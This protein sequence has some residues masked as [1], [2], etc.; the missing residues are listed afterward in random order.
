MKRMASMALATLSS[1]SSIACSGD[2]SSPSGTTRHV[3]TVFLIVMENKAW[4]ELKGSDKAPYLNDT[5]LPMASHAEGYK[6]PKNG[7]LH[8]SEP[9]YIWLEAG[10]NLG[11]TNDDDP[12]KNHLAT[13]DHLVTYMEQAGVSWKSY[14]EDIP[15]SECPLT[16]VGDYKPKHDPMVF[17][18]DVTDGN[19]PQ[20]ERCIA[21]N[22]P[23]T[24][25]ETDLA[26]GTVAKYNF[27]TPNQCNDMHSACAPLSDEVAQGDQWLSEWIPKMMAS[28][29]YQDDGAIFITWDEAE[30]FQSCL[31]NCEIGMIV[32]SPLA[33]GGGYQNTVAYDHSSTLKTVQEIF[34]IEP[35]LGAAAASETEDLR[36]LFKSL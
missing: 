36:A 17:F 13:T 9:N 18:D 8:P 29:A 23:L 25:L 26:D 22:R 33:K 24:E 11:I 10:D 5:I 14:Q 7:S 1:L 32:L 12:D 20:S 19:D 31:G 27:V 30:L 16:S 4:A 28:A 2:D 35:L 6:G 34:G 15:G 3:K 21:H